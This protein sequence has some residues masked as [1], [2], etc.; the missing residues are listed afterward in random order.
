[1]LGAIETIRIGNKEQVLVSG[2]EPSIDERTELKRE[3]QRIAIRIGT[4]AA[5]AL[6]AD[7]TVRAAQMPLP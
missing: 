1:M 2:R 5:R 7:L 3:L 6:L 4:D